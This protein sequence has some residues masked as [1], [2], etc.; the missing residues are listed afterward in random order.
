MNVSISKEQE[1]PL[2]TKKEKWNSKHQ[3]HKEK[4]R[5]KKKKKKKV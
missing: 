4:A 5:D 3:T 1:T 2:L